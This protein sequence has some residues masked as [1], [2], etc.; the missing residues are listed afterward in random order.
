MTKDSGFKDETFAFY[1]DNAREFYL[2]TVNINMAV[3]YTPFIG[4]MP[5]Y[6]WILDAGCGSGRDALY[7]ANKG[8]RVTAFDT[9]P[10]LVKLASKLTGQ[11]VL[12]LSFQELDFE[13]QFDGIWAC[14]SLFH[15]PMDE[16]HDVLA[17]LSRAMKVNGIMYISYKYGAGEHYRDG[18]LFVDFNED[19]FDKLIHTHPDLTVLRYWKTNDLR[20]GREKEKWLNILVR[21]TRSVEQNLEP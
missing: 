13:N 20:S 5:P 16:H 10:A 4:Y 18:R 1:E 21:K 12:E 2:D 17:R 11:Q 14:S 6:A 3:L 19:G 15:V 7:F 8:F 9:S